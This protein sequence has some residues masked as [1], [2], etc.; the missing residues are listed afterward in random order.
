MESLLL[1]SSHRG[2]INLSGLELTDEDLSSSILSDLEG[3]LRWYLSF[4]EGWR[5][6]M[7]KEL[8]G[9][10]RSCDLGHNLLTSTASSL[11]SLEKVAD[12]SNSAAELSSQAITE[13]RIS[14]SIA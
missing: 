9:H 2:G 4:S 6:E 3:V 5:E 13:S 1:P 14:Q 11:T 10:V 7:V 12:V 8:L